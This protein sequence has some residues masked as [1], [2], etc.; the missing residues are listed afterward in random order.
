MVA[1][2]KEAVW[3]TDPDNGCQGVNSS[4]LLAFAELGQ[5]LESFGGE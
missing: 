4:S 2:V 3:K 5:N 1:S